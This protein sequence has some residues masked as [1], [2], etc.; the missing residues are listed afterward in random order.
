MSLA[1]QNPAASTQPE[2]TGLDRFLLDTDI[3]SLRAEHADDAAFRRAAV[4][5]FRVGAR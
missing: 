4:D 3:A 2:T 5:R 1:L